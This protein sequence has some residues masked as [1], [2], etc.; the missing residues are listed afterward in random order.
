MSMDTFKDRQQ[1]EEIY[2]S[3]K[4]PWQVWNDAAQEAQGLASVGA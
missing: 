3:G 2:S 1:L 4:A